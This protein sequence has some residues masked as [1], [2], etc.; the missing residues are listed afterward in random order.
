MDCTIIWSSKQQ[1]CVTL[2]SPEAEYVALSEA[3]KEIKFLYQVLESLGVKVT[4][5]IIV[6]VDNVGAIFMAENVSAT[7]R[8]R[9]VDARYHFV[10]EFQFDGFI[11]IVFVSTKDNRADP[12]TKNTTSDVYNRSIDDYMVSKLFFRSH[13]S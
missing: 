9:H 5:P 13:G 1:A 12:Y 10:R 8:S 4:L 2:S 3:A 7:K 6:H 11:K